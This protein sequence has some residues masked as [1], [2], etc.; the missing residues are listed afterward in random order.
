MNE[1]EMAKAMSNALYT[2]SEHDYNCTCEGC[3]LWWA[4]MGPDGG[5]P[6]DYGP[7]KKDEVNEKQ[8]EFGLDVTD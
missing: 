5:T 2:N 1:V 8:I 6:G 4:M 7:F 3:C